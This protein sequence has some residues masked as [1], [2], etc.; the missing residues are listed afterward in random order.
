ME[1]WQHGIEIERLRA[2]AALFKERHNALVFGAF[3][4]T[5]ER[6]IAEALSKNNVIWTGDPPDAVAL[7]A[8]AK[9]DSEQ[10]DFAQR[11][12]RIKI[13]AV[14]VK[15]FAARSAEAGAKILG[16]LRDRAVGVA[17]WVE[18]FEED[19]T[20]RAA[21]AAAGG[22]N[23]VATKIAAGSEIKGVYTTGASQLP[24]IGP[25]DEATLALL[26]RAFLAEGESEAIL[27]ELSAFDSLWAQHYSSYNKRKSWEAFA[28]RGYTDDPGFII[29]PREMSRKWKEEHADLLEAKSRPTKAAEHFPATLKAVARLARP[30]QCDRVRFMRLRAKDGELSRHADITDREA[31]TRDGQICRLH[32]PIVTS[33]KVRFYGWTARGEAIVTS[34]SAGALAYLDQRKPH[35]VT[36]DDPELWRIH[37]V[38]DYVADAALRAR[39]AAA[40]A[41]ARAA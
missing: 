9:Q 35:R 15:A 1:T 21:L 39:L 30:E 32:I 40:V 13:P 28:L 18:I 31:G 24:P 22:F 8:L 17:L 6:D 14:H 29:K 26:E 23:Y 16:A 2:F 20:A 33:P 19:A 41:P 11:P 5:K 10:H 12:F 36:N 38:V 34:F 37:L 27:C 25:E 4:L 3:G 7:F